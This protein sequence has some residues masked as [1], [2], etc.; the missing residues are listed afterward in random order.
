M[1]ISA[2]SSALPI[3]QSIYHKAK[4]I[5][6][7]TCTAMGTLSFLGFDC[8]TLTPNAESWFMVEFRLP[9]FHCGSLPGCEEGVSNDSSGYSVV[10][11]LVMLAL[12]AH[13]LISLGLTLQAI[14]FVNS[15]A[16]LY[17]V[18]ADRRRAARSFY[19][20]LPA[21]NAKVLPRT[22]LVSG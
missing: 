3:L 20:R 15:V 8:L 6:R 1:L 12:L 13:T 16:Y 10:V 11:I 19:Q 9:Q 17:K 2:I 18:P 22:P 7:L 4:R 14:E 21:K 5:S